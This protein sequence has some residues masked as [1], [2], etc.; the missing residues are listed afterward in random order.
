MKTVVVIPDNWLN[1]QRKRTEMT[2]MSYGGN[3]LQENH[4][5]LRPSYINIRKGVESINREL[6]KKKTEM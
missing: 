6:E 3:K 1:N 2:L 5:N 4:E